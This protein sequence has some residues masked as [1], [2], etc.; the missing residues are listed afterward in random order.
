MKKVSGFSPPRPSWSSCKLSPGDH[1][2]F[3]KAFLIN[4]PKFKIRYFH[5][6]LALV[7]LSA[8]CAKS[9]PH[10][11]PPSAPI[12]RHPGPDRV[13]SAR[14]VDPGDLGVKTTSFNLR[15]GVSTH[16]TLS[17]EFTPNSEAAQSWMLFAQ[18]I[19]RSFL[20]SSFSTPSTWNQAATFTKTSSKF[21]KVSFGVFWIYL[22]LAWIKEI[23]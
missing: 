6:L 14:V 1:W 10:L 19:R 18:R 7:L 13:W 16:A 11:L 8:W 23:E 9:W 3:F 2:K 21:Q 4:V 5:S 15:L 22:V 17:Y 20:S 12:S